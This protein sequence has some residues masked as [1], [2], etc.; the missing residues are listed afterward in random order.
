MRKQLYYIPVN[1]IESDKNDNIYTQSYRTVPEG[2][3]IIDDYPAINNNILMSIPKEGDRELVLKMENNDKSD[4]IVA[5][6]I[7]Y[8]NQFLGLLL[9]NSVLNEKY[10]IRKK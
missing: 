3:C 7:I 9:P 6:P 8:N 10:I 4:K 1:V 5:K 2:L